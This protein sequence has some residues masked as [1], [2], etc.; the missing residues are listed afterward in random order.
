MVLMLVVCLLAG[1]AP[2]RRALRLEP[3]AALRADG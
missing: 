3:G 2:A 1:V